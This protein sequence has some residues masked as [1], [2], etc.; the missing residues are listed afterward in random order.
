[1]TAIVAGDANGENAFSGE[2][3][4]RYTIR[5]TQQSAH[6][7]PNLG[8]GPIVEM[9]HGEKGGEVGKGGFLGNPT[10][11]PRETTPAAYWRVVALSTK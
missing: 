6:P 9:H 3:I 5:P 4:E 7:P 2:E 1:M 8:M 11:T 10:S